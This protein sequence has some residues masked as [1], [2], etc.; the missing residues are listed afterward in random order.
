MIKDMTQDEISLYIIKVLK[1]N[2][3]AEF[4]VILEE[5]QPY[6]IAKIY[7]ELPG[8]H[9]AKFLLF[10]K[11]DLLADLMEELDKD[12]QLEVLNK[13][14][15]EK[16][17]K[18]LDLMDNDDLA[19]LLHE[20]SPEKMDSLLSGMKAEESTAVKGILNYPPETARRIMTNRFVW[21]RN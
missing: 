12:E 17:S 4:E 2:K 19:L 11:N 9:K 7:E 8:K 16:S 6:D 20:L 13:L 15:I 14:G 10:L 21:I 18:V 1:E 3:K 5:L